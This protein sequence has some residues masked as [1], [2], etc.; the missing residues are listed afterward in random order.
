MIAR[1]SWT[2]GGNINYALQ[3]KDSSGVTVNY[4]LGIDYPP[5]NPPN[6]ARASKNLW[7][8]LVVEQGFTLK[9]LTF[10]NIVLVSEIFLTS[11]NGNQHHP[12]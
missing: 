6:I 2:C 1:T 12:I 10:A 11:L 5:K 3:S 8:S 9:L 7:K 4:L